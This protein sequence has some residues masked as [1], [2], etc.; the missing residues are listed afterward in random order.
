M[1]GHIWPL[2][3]FI[4]DSCR[5]LKIV[6]LR[7]AG[8]PDITGETVILVL[9]KKNNDFHTTNEKISIV[10]FRDPKS[11]SSAGIAGFKVNHYRFRSNFQ[12]VPHL[13]PGGTIC[14]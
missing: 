11:P 9:E 12:I 3:H 5:V 4:L 1:L 7:T 6:D 13:P 14:P 8:F 10:P 2:R